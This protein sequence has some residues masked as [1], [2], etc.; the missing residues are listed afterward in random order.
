VP[1]ER[2]NTEQSGAS[3]H[4]LSAT[5]VD[6]SLEHT[7]TVI[8]RPIPLRS[9]GGRAPT[10]NRL[11]GM[12]GFP[13]Q[14]RKVAATLSDLGIQDRIRQLPDSAATAASAAQAL[15]VDKAAIANSL[16]FEADGRPL[17]VIISGAHRADLLKLA[18][19][20]D[21]RQVNRADPSF[22]RLHTGQPIGGVSPVGHPRP[23]ETLVDVTL[24]RQRAVWA[25]AGHPQYVFRTSY[26]ELLRI[27]AGNAGEV[28]EA[29][30]E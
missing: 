5:A 2:G 21:S 10:T 4:P 25:S 24:S 9:I 12:E 16:I 8:R 13:P 6:E 7:P 1:T 30:A 28:G 3:D 23:I 26:D 17:L 11:T 15:D 29:P 19:L 22:V 18:S 27:T 20:T 14:V